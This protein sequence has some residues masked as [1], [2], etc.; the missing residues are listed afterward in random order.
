MAVRRSGMGTASG[1]LQKGPS[2]TAPQLGFCKDALLT[3]GQIRGCLVPVH[4]WMPPFSRSRFERDGEGKN[5]AQCQS[6]QTTARRLLSGR[7]RGWPHRKAG[8]LADRQYSVH[9]RRYLQVAAW[10]VGPHPKLG[11]FKSRQ[12]CRSLPKWAG[13]RPAPCSVLCAPGSLTCRRWQRRL[14]KRTL[15]R[16]G[17]VAHLAL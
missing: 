9:V 1:V 11:R 14:R 2:Y 16:R 15:S 7:K 13:H 12:A 5:L 3:L 10:R 6:E 4:I 8:R 17:R